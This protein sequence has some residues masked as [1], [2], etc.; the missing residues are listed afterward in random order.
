MFHQ[1]TLIVTYERVPV[2][3][4]IE[5]FICATC[6][7]WGLAHLS[8][9]I[10]SMTGASVL[11]HLC[12]SCW[13]RWVFCVSDT[14]GRS[15]LRKRG[16]HKLITMVIVNPHQLRCFSQRLHSHVQL[17]PRNTLIAVLQKNKK[18]KMCK[19][20]RTPRYIIYSMHQSNTCKL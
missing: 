1:Q 16:V 19:S 3:T 4:E 20:A 8:L 13:W 10:S 14:V 11:S 7:W 17:F 6:V 2:M 5:L 12:F 15:S 9:A 18:Q